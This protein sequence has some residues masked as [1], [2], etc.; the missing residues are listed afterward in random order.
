MALLACVHSGQVPEARPVELRLRPEDLPGLAANLHVDSGLRAAAE[1]LVA[2]STR[3][4]ARL[5]PEAARLALGRAGYPRDAHFLHARGADAEIPR[6]L[7]DA[8]PS[9]I[10][11]DIGWAS[12]PTGAGGYTWVVGWAPQVGS[13]D[14]MPRDVV[15]DRGLP[16]RVDGLA[17]PRLFIGSP[18]GRAQELSLADGQARWVDVFHIP[19]EYRVEVVEGDTVAFLFSLYVDVPVP[20]A[21]PL[22]G[23]APG[24]EPVQEAAELAAHVNALRTGVGLQPLRPFATF[25]ELTR[26]QATCLASIGEVGHRSA[27][28]PGVP[29]M[30]EHDYYPRARY[31][32]DVVAADTAEEAWERLYDSPGHRL[33][34]LCAACTHIVV[35]AALEPTIPARAFAVL[36]L[37]EFP[38]GE[39]RPIV[40]GRE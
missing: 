5:V 33:N 38:E 23:A 20:A 40:R 15:L 37:M 24:S 11:V 18:D 10:P 9:G 30:A 36:D 26:A 31:H 35:G 12:R 28:C 16:L 1:E 19:G 6:S 34:L 39:P 25:E 2:D 27:R 4:D 7:L 22:P 13:I 3:E 21:V 8:I 14:P 32:E 17:D 29:A